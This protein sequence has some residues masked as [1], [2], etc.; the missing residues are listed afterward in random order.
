MDLMK[1]SKEHCFEQNE[2]TYHLIRREVRY[3]E[4][5]INKKTMKYIT[6][7]EIGRGSAPGLFLEQDTRNTVCMFAMLL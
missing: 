1:T 6:C 3:D 7:K 5:K 2:F 4:Q